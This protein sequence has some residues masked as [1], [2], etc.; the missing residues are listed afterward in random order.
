MTSHTYIHTYIH[1]YTHTNPSGVVLANYNIPFFLYELNTQT[2][3]LEN[4]AGDAG[5]NGF[6]LGGRALASE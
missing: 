3:K 6:S 4:V 5:I 2:D 1:T